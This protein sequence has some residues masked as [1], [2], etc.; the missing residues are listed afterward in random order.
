MFEAGKPFERISFE[1]LNRRLG[2]TS[3]VDRTDCS[4][5]RRAVLSDMRTI[6]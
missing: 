2:I 4:E 3:L 1:L 6:Y 5:T